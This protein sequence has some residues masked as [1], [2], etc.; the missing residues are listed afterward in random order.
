MGRVITQCW[1]IYAIKA[2]LMYPSSNGLPPCCADE[3]CENDGVGDAP[4]CE[5]DLVG[6]ASYC[7]FSPDLDCYP[8]AM[9]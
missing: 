4:P 1:T 3:T 7:T 8:T 9:A 2:V 6:G 5:G